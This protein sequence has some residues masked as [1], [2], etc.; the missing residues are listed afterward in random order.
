MRKKISAFFQNALLSGC[1]PQRLTLSCCLGLYI[2]FS[3]FPGVH[4]IIMLACN[5]FFNLHFPTLLIATSINNPWTM[6]PF[7]LFDYNFG[8]WFV[9]SL[10]GW[11]PS[12][13]F[14]LTKIFGST[15]ICIWSFL[16]GGNVAGIAVALVSYPLLLWFFT[17]LASHFNNNENMSMKS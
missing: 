3:P 1:T 10:M 9:H 6:I 5:Y 14:S 11:Q 7:Y 12:L 16:I 15:K 17:R 4:T 13:V 2:A 8:Y